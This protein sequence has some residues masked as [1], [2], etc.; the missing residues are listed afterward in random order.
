MESFMAILYMFP[1]LTGPSFVSSMRLVCVG[2]VRMVFILFGLLLS[3][4][5][6]DQ[7]SQLGDVLG[8]AVKQSPTASRSVST[9]TKSGTELLPNEFRMPAD[10]VAAPSGT[11]V[12]PRQ[13][14]VLGLDTPT[15]GYI[16]MRSKQSAGAVVN[17]YRD[18]MIAAGWE[19]L[20]VTQGLKNFVAFHRKS[21][22]NS[23]IAAFVVTQLQGH[24]TYK[25]D[26]ELFVALA[27]SN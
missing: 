8:T 18:K 13:S 3:S 6:L 20:A 27:E 5:A 10:V 17:Y 7:N 14:F 26:I 15:N 23:R 21:N 12:D 24:P 9:G 25:S 2:A 16:L 4:C 19:P 1:K 11:V 22:S